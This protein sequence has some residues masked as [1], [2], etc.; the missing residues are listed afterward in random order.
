[1]HSSIGGL[2][3][4]LERV[5]GVELNDTEK[6]I[7]YKLR[8]SIGGLKELLEGVVSFFLAETQIIMYL[9]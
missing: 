8:S 7:K 4:L 6:N 5:E 9:V 3:E 2:K 1:L